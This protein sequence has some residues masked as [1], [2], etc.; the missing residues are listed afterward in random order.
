[1][2]KKDP[3]GLLITHLQTVRDDMVF[4]TRIGDVPT[5][6]LYPELFDRIKRLLITPQRKFT[7]HIQRVEDAGFL[8]AIVSGK[9]FIRFT[10]T[11][12]TLSFTLPF[13]ATKKEHKE[14]LS[15]SE[16]FQHCFRVYT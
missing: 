5:P 13:Q 11:N 2:F 6:E 16:G 7:T 8:M 15:E 14:R 4:L 12:Q 3:V 10:Q 9:L 1:M